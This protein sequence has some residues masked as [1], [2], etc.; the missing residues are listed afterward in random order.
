MLA[1]LLFHFIS[2]LGSVYISWRGLSLFK[3]LKKTV[4]HWLFTTGV[5]FFS[6]SYFQQYQLSEMLQLTWFVIGLLSL[7]SY[8]IVLR[9]F[10]SSVRSRGFNTRSFVIAGGGRLGQKLLNKIS[11]NQ[12]LGLIFKGYYDDHNVSRSS[13]DIE[14]EGDLERLVADCKQGRGVRG[15]GRR[16]QADFTIPI[17]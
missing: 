10:L 7:I 6:L 2:E 5:C 16:D 9:L 12:A 15:Q 11:A 4:I 13:G 3:E 8:R 17:P 1:A 14:I